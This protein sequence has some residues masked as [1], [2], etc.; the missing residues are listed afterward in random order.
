MWITWL[1]ICE[2]LENIQALP[3]PSVDFDHK[4]QG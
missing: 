3:Y 1:I 4:L 2:L